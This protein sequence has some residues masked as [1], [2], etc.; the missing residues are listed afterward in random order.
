MPTKKDKKKE[1]DGEQKIKVTAHE[2]CF[3]KLW[4]TGE[5]MQTIGNRN[6]SFLLSPNVILTVTLKIEYKIQLGENINYSF[7]LRLYGQSQREAACCYLRG[8]QMILSD[9]EASVNQLL[10]G[11]LLRIPQLQSCLPTKKFYLEIIYFRIRF[12]GAQV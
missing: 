4:A 3:I 6:H 7:P 11:H 8:V 2:R 10:G 1:K 9:A 5:K 12:K